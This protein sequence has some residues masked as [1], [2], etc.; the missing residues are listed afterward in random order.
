MRR[1]A[2]SALLS[3]LIVA[4]RE[5]GSWC[6]ETHV[7]KATLLLEELFAVPLEYDFILYKHGPFSFDLRDELTA[8]R[9]DNL[10]ELDAQRPYGPR[11]VPTKQAEYISNLYVRTV[12]KYYDHIQAVAEIV[13]SRGVQE[14]ER[15]ATALFITLQSNSTKDVFERAVEITRIKPHVTRED[16][17]SALV[18]IDS[19]VQKYRAFGASISS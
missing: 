7:Q 9:S 6:G 16:A 12:R 18:E 14:L 8:M 1:L 10:L 5:H 15:L 4:L 11:I 19:L 3:Q 13:G 17:V 2:K